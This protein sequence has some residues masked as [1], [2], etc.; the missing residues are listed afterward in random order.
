MRKK[1]YIF[2]CKEQ[3]QNEWITEVISART[4]YEACSKL[5]SKYLLD[6][7]VGTYYLWVMKITHNGDTVYFGPQRMDTILR[8]LNNN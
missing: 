7:G 5:A 1:E 4:L 3:G 8:D 2:R 6:Y